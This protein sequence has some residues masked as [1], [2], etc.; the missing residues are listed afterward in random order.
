[1]VLKST[2][3]YLILLFV[4]FLNFFGSQSATCQNTEHF[5]LL[6]KVFYR[7]EILKINAQDVYQQV[8]STRNNSSVKLILNDRTEWN[9]VLEN[10][11]IIAPDYIATEAT[12]AGIIKKTGTTALPMQGY[13]EGAPGS[14]VSLTFNEDFIYG[15]IK[16]GTVSY[17]IEPLYHYITGGARNNFVLYSVN[18]IIPTEE[19]TCGYDKYIKEEQR[20]K[21]SDQFNAGSRMPGGCK[22]LKYCTASDWLMVQGY[23]NSQGVQNHNI[24]VLNNVQ[25][26]Y[27]SSFADELRFQLTEQWVSSC[28]TCDP[29][30]SSTDPNILLNSFTS[31]AVGGFSAPHNVASLW[32]RRDFDGSTIGLA[33]VGVLCTPNRYHVLQD[34]S[35]NADLKRV[36]TAHEIGHNLNASHNTGIMAPTVSNTNVWSSISVSEINAHYMSA[37][38][39][40][41]CPSSSP[42]TPD[43]LYNVLNNCTPAYVQFTN[44]STNANSVSWTFPG[45]TPATSTQQ[46]PLVFF[47]TGGTINVTLSATNTAGTSSLTLPVTVNILPVPVSNFIY[48]AAGTVVSFIYTGSGG[49]SYLWNFGD[50][51][52]N[53]NSQNP[54]HAY[55]QNGNYTVSLTVSNSCGSHTVSYVVSIFVVPAPNFTANPTSGCQPRTVVFTN[56]TNNA[57]SYFWSFPGGNPGTSTETNPVVIYNTPGLHNVTLQA[58]NDAGNN[59]VVKNN[60]INISP[61]PTAGFTF[62]QSG[63][64]VFFTNQGLNGST[65]AWN[66]G[67]GSSSTE[68]NPVHGFND[69]GVYTV[70]QTVTNVCGNVSSTQ[71]VTIALPPVASFVPAANDTICKGQSVLF[72]STSG[73]S[74]TS[75]LWT[76]EGGTPS[77][78]TSPNPVVTYNQSGVFDVTLV[79]TN[80]NGTTTSNFNDLIIVNDKPQVSFS[81]IGDEL[82]IYFTQNVVNGTNATWNFGDGQTS[83]AVN[84][85]HSYALQGTYTVSLTDNNQCGITTFT[86]DILVQLLPT[87]GFTSDVTE[88]CSPSGIQFT[89][90]SSPSV[91][92]WAWTFEGGTPS[93]SDLRNPFV[94][95]DQPGTYNVSLTVTNASGQST[96]SLDDYISI[97]T[98]PSTT[99]A[100]T[101]IE[102]K[103][104][105]ENTAPEAKSSL[106]H[107]FNDNISI[108]FDSIAV[109][110][111]APSNG[112]YYVVLTNR[113]QCGQS[114]S[115]TISLYVNAYPESSFSYNN[116]GA[117]C[118]LSKVNFESSSTNA[119]EFYWT[120]DGGQPATSTLKNP[121]VEF[122]LSGTHIVTLIVG[123]HLGQD[124][125][126]TAVTIDEKPISDFEYAIS[127]LSNVNFEYTGTGASDYE[128]LFGDGTF[129]TES[130][131]TH[132]YNLSGSYNVILISS[133]DCGRDTI[134][135]T[136][137]TI[138]SGSN[139]LNAITNLTVSPNPS[140]GEFAINISTEISGLWNLTVSDILGRIIYSNRIFV[141]KNNNLHLLD[142]SNDAGGLYILTLN[143]ENARVSRKILIAK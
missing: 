76:F 109:N 61:Q 43:F 56:Q 121:D 30:P 86:R 51:T 108:T 53:S 45:G 8:K 107:I 122:A 24:G 135:R 83:N 90:Q 21:S 32:S 38:C 142:M 129:S 120:F 130:N 73:F 106:W 137:V 23:G 85:T 22:L 80:A 67:D 69:N 63:P 46:N 77:S 88:A 89:S 117:A 52:P 115:D 20:I 49:S 59:T 105:L 99:F 16:L 81:Q 123:N 70:T 58:F 42:P 13:V 96:L 139:D 34:F 7:Y 98:I 54:T 9:M 1:M 2:K 40:Q 79:A 95:Y 68:A 78:S 48:N 114:I 37:S 133:N 60:F 6:D 97:I 11:G 39:L 92:E 15:F 4:I 127:N 100:D 136:I 102:N 134:E 5:P 64:S 103:I 101:V 36:M 55:S 104:L 27:T 50:N 93:T 74:P 124:T 111:R 47:T 138:G 128:W 118:V 41:N 17:Y 94:T 33:W 25:T 141:N 143:N 66:F 126:T 12:E 57:T 18:D 31:W 19:K 3:H 125:L 26:N 112:L 140:T 71:Q 132:I 110:Y 113:N 44:Q 28:S 91:T 62:A 10:S 29:W 14:S 84:P 116:G 75:L 131:P 119:T 87:A 82:T 72:Q 35:T 65:F